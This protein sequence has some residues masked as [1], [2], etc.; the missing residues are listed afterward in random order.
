MGV[1]GDSL[2]VS[3]NVPLLIRC[4]VYLFLGLFVVSL[5]TDIYI[6]FHFAIFNINI[7]SVLENAIVIL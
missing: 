7:V 2:C 4:I 3:F 1:G 5:E 6:Y